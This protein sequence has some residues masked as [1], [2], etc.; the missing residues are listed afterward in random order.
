MRRIGSILA[1]AT[2]A[3]LMTGCVERRYVITTDPPGAAVY[4]N[5]E[6]IGNA[7]VDDPFVYYGNYH[8][9]I[10]KEGFATLQINQ[11][12]KTPFYEYW[13][14]DFVSENLVPFHIEDVRYLHYQMQPL[15]PPNI[16]ALLNQG[17]NLRNEG[18]T[19]AP[20]HPQPPAQPAA[21]PP[22]LAPPA[23]PAPASIPPGGPGQ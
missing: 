6:F 11:D 5:G 3:G 2:L 19:L 21:T 12:I 22:V 16:P 17:Q 8:Y 23:V 4:R 15:P 1:V 10:R 20:K 9:T 7:P 14:L 13:P 18:R